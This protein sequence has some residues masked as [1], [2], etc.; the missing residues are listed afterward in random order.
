MADYVENNQAGE[1]ESSFDFKALFQIFI[2]NWQYVLLSVIFFVGCGFVYLRYA[3]PVYTASMKLLIKDDDSRRTRSANGIA[4]D[5]LGLM[6][7][8]SGF[9]NELEILTSTSLANRVVKNLKLYVNYVQEGRLTSR[10]VYKNSP[11]IVD[12]EEG[13][14]DE[15]EYPIFLTISKDDEVIHVSGCRY[16]VPGQEPRYPCF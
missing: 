16:A 12:F 13:R 9:D 11:I 14:L 5:R 8:S 6:T 1:E 2:L 7:N 4:M 15:L 3:T 10:E